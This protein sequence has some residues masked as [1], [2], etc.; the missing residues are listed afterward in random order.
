MDHPEEVSVK[1]SNEELNAGKLLQSTLVKVKALFQEHGFVKIENIFPVKLIEQL[2]EYYLQGLDFDQE[3]DLGV[4]AKVSHKRYIVPVLL[5]G[6]FND[7]L[8][9]ANPLL[10]PIL[11]SLLGQ[12]MVISSIGSVTSLPGSMDQ[13]VHADY[14]PLFEDDL[15]SSCTVPTFAVT[16][17]I[18][19]VDIDVI[20]GPTKVWSGSH[21][22]YP[23]NQD[24]APYPKHLVCGPKGSCYFWDYRTF[25]AGGSNHSEE[26][27]P[28]LYLAYTRRWFHD[29]L[30]PDHMMIDEEEYKKIPKDYKFLFAKHIAMQARQ[31]A[32]V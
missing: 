7:P 30:N 26:I 8:L 2:S 25:H 17:G 29:F 12:F 20:N 15:I 14:L 16:M 1:L 21:K 18:P 4:G 5:K 11:K 13:H 32:L 19:L 24:L 22:I 3:G 10:M 31:K 9:Y 23:R 28:L 6:P 27:R